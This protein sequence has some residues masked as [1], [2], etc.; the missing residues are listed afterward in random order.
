MKK[1]A[2][3]GEVISDK[4]C[5]TVV[6]GKWFRRKKKHFHTNCFIANKRKAKDITVAMTKS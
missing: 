1:C 5:V 4:R 6:V 2:L 3:C